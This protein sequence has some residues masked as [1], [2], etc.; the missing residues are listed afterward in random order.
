MS[1]SPNKMRGSPADA[2]ERRHEVRAE[3]ANQHVKGLLLINGGS[4]AALLAFLQAIW[5]DNPNLAKWVLLALGF[6]CLGV[7]TAGFSNWLR[8]MTSLRFQDGAPSRFA[9]SNLSY[10][11]QHLSLVCFLIAAG[12]LLFGAWSLIPGPV[13]Q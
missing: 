3:I 10:T 4:A 13:S 11:V 12:T 1:E 6:L 9:W 7:A 2:A 5:A 8:Y